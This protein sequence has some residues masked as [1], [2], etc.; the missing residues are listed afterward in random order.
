MVHYTVL[1]PGRD[2]ADALARLVPQLAAALDRLILPYEIIAIDDASGE[3]AAGALERQLSENRHLRVLRFDRPRGASAAL[4]AGIAAS[5]GDLVI[6][7]CP[8]T[9]MAA[10]S[11]PH[12]ISRLS[13]WDFVV[14]KP[15][16]TAGQYLRHS[17]A[18][19][20]RILTAERRRDAAQDLFFAARREALVGLAL[21]PGGCRILPELMASRGFRVCRLTI[22]PGLPP[23]GEHYRVGW[24]KRL[25][26]GWLGRRFEPHL[27]RELAPYAA[28]PNPAA[29]AQQIGPSRLALP[30]APTAVETKHAK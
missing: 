29:S 6:G 27:A 7:I 15:E 28:R 1:V 20:P 26:A 2:T 11:I 13:R 22:A 18:G 14:A 9:R 21:A 4:S 30:A 8:D 17:L 3:P 24:L 19:V 10:E 25:A 16:R 12:M 23:R 5:R